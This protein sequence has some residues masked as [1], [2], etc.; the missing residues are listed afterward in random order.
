MD[1][2]LTLPQVLQ[3]GKDFLAGLTGR[4]R[5][6]L[7]GGA[8]LVAAT[9]CV[10]VQLIAKPEYKTLY[11]GLSSERYP[12]HRRPPGEQEDSLRAVSRRRQHLGARRQAGQRASGDCLAA[13]AAQRAHGLRIVRQAQLGGQRLQ[14]EGELPARPGSRTGAHPADPQRSGGGAGAPGHAGRIVV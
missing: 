5:L 10:F 2:N 1:S 8:V 3:Q 6:L 11:S 12:G 4:Q 9:L 14:R 13:H 7:G